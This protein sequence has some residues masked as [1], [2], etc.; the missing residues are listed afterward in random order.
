[1]GWEGDAVLLKGHRM[2]APILSDLKQE[3]SIGR[4][5]YSLELVEG[6]KNKR[7]M[8]LCIPADRSIKIKN[9]LKGNKALLV[10]IHEIL[11]GL[12]YEYEIGLTHEQIHKL[13]R[14]VMDF[15]LDNW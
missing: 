14:P 12:D 13:E 3:W 11:H 4:E 9:S 7:V 5:E 1:M 10:L 8:G 2:K 6:F 15:V